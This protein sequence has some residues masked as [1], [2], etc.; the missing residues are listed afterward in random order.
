M[1][2]AKWPRAQLRMARQPPVDGRPAAGNVR[3]GA[4]AQ[5]PEF[6]EGSEYGKSV[7]DGFLFFSDENVI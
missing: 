4:S 1:E 5:A 3:S 2:P 7:R 6:G